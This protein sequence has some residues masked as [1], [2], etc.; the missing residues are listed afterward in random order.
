MY[1]HMNKKSYIL[2]QLILAI[3]SL[4]AMTG[5]CAICTIF[6]SYS[7]A[8]VLH[9]LLAVIGVL[10]TFITVMFNSSTALF[11][12]MIVQARL[13]TTSL[14]L[15]TVSIIYLL[16][17]AVL[18]F[19]IFF[20]PSSWKFNKIGILGVTD[21]EIHKNGIILIIFSLLLIPISVCSLGVAIRLFRRKKFDTEETESVKLRKFELIVQLFQSYA[22]ITFESSNIHCTHNNQHF[23]MRNAELIAEVVLQLLSSNKEKNY[24]KKKFVS[25]F[26]FIEQ[27]RMKQSGRP[28]ASTVNCFVHKN[29]YEMKEKEPKNNI[30]EEDMM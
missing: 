1:R 13:N 6:F 20:N 29:A 2:C 27:L 24:D 18:S 8:F 5:F 23:N 30:D 17:I 25:F 21:E 22:M 15:Q 26:E 4:L 19:N 3:C 10:A 28:K 12:H 11:L 9:V 7:G 14:L 16:I